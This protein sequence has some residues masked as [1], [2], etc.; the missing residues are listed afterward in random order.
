VF[1][2]LLLAVLAG[3]SGDDGAAEKV[4]EAAPTT[5]ALPTSTSPPAGSTDV[6]ATPAPVPA[7]AAQATTEAAPEGV[8]AVQD[9]PVIDPVVFN[10]DF[11]T[12]VAPIFSKKC[13]SCH[14]AGGPGATHWQLETA[15]DLASTHEW[16]NGV[17]ATGYMPPWPASDISLVF[18]E[19]RSLRVDEIEAVAAWSAAGAPL[20]VDPT[21]AIVSPDGVAV[22]DADLEVGPHEPYQGS[23]A[24]PDDYRCLI[25]DPELTEAQWMQGFEFVPDQTA[26]VHHAIGY[27]VP[28]RELA[29]AQGLSGVDAAGGWQCYGGSGLSGDAL[30]LGWAPGQ[31]ATSFPEGSGILVEPGD[32]VVL[33]VHY[34]Y[35]IEAPADSST[36]RFD[37]ADGDNLDPIEF[38][39][40]I[41]PA[42]IPCASTEAGPLCDRD[43][44]LARA[45][46]QYGVEGVLADGINSLCGVTAADFADMTSGIASSGCVIPV[47]EFGE[48]VSVFGHQHEIGKSIRMTLNA[49]RSDE[50]ILLDI[51]DWS[52]DW[53]Y[54]YYPVESIMLKPGDEVLLECSWDRS[55]RSP[56]LEPAYVLWADG[57]NDEMCFATIS[58]RTEA[59]SQVVAPS[60]VIQDASGFGANIE[61]PEAVAACM[62]DAGVPL[63]GFPERQD[64]DATVDQLYR[65]AP[66]EEIGAQLGGLIA[67]N[68]DG[69]VGDDDIE[70][71]AERLADPSEARSLLVFV[72]DDSTAQERQPVGEL[73]GDC[74]SLSTAIENFGFPLPEDTRAC[75][76]EVGRD[77][78][79]QATI[80][81]ELPEAQTLFGSINP[82]LAG[83]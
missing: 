81:G 48:I 35:D 19:N 9:V 49:G 38:D 10:D 28:A 27:L 31:L 26:I 17:V 47:R 37:W 58:T 74:V 13:A 16:I 78:L 45:Y 83:G 14:N 76:D 40:Y 29:N 33:Q 11:G 68:F 12:S 56:D 42:E 36:L 30:F 7:A 21:L 3:C 53:Q 24:V 20:D 73:V 50:R 75:V 69:L 41:G 22:L 46:S 34:H 71:L 70:C 60:D 54:N 25:Y 77:L 59:G 51:P 67:E 80:D 32:F 8:S 52:F 65:C 61:I 57:T 43:A 82:C 64:I 63:E 2:F 4:T 6:P 5:A 23:T 39:E 72:L 18:H 66:A 1:S 55:R 44:A 15:A 79:V 62:S